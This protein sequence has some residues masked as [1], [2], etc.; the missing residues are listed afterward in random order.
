[1]SC[2]Q[3]LIEPNDTILKRLCPICELAASL[4]K[5]FLIQQKGNIKI[6]W[7]GRMKMNC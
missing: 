4:H 7:K 2:M 6:N 1:M 3:I 5:K